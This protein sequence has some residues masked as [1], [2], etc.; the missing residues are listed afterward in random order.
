MN[1]LTPVLVSV[2]D[3]LYKL[4]YIR[5]GSDGSVYIVFPRKNGY[6]ISQEK[7]LKEIRGTQKISL[8]ATEEVFIN[9]HVSFHPRS[10][11]IHV[12][13]DR[14]EIYRGDKSILN[15]A[16]SEKTT[17]EYIKPLIINSELELLKCSIGLEFWVHPKDTW[18]DI[19]ETP[20]FSKRVKDTKIIGMF[21]FQHQEL[22]K[23]TTSTIVSEISNEDNGKVRSG[24]LKS[25]IIVVFNDDEPYIFQLDPVKE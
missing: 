20:N 11:A 19:T 6:R 5:F 25:I 9:P 3:K 12:K 10:Q 2:N 18:F 22:G 14:K 8:S 13:T 15:M 1:I 21:K 4:L 7:S 23:F 16:E 24:L 17:E